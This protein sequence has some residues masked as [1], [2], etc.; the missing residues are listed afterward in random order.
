MPGLLDSSSVPGAAVAL[1]RKVKLCEQ[2]ALARLMWL[3]GPRK[4]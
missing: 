4:P 2:K 1:I 3:E